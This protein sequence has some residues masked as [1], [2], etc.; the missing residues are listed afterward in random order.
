MMLWLNEIKQD[1]ENYNQLRINNDN[2]YKSQKNRVIGHVT[3][4]KRNR[5]PK[6]TL[7]SKFDS[8][9]IGSHKTKWVTGVEKYLRK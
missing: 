4:M 3:R 9:C 5:V 6:V 2:R 8:R 1:I 7:N